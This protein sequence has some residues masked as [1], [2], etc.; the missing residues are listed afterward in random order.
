MSDDAATL[1]LFGALLRRARVE[2]GLTQR[3]VGDRI[4][5]Y[6]TYVSEYERG[7]YLPDTR[8]LEGL[9]EVLGLA[10]APEVWRV[11]GMKRRSKGGWAGVVCLVEGCERPVDSLGLCSLHYVPQR[12]ARNRAAGRLCMVQGCGPGEYRGGLSDVQDGRAPA[13]GCTS[14]SRGA[15][16]T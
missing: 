9:V 1:A 11:A 12:E 4:G 10:I 5:V 3:H 2:A 15:P 16:A 13:S 8:R 7:R 6:Q 14:C